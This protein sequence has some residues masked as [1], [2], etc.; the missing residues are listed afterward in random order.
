MIV[1][2][3]HYRSDDPPADVAW[4]LVAV[5]L[6]DLA[7]KGAKPVGALLGY[8]LGDSDWD[9]AFAQGLGTA[10]GA[11]G[12]P[13]LGGDTVAMPQGAPRALG[14]TALG[15]TE[16]APARSGAAPGDLL[17]VSGTIGDA[18]AGLDLLNR[19]RTEPAALIE[20]YRNPRPRLEAGQRLTPL[21]TAM[22]DVSDGLLI[23]ASRMAHASGCGAEIELD[24]I[25]L[26]DALLAER[27]ADRSARLDAATA[28]DDYEL[29]FAAAPDGAPAILALA[30]EIGLPFTRIGRFESGAGLILRDA[31]GPVPLPARTGFE[32]GR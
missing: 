17:W 3:V 5:N 27:G 14:L 2:G 1:E 8:A 22:M 32:H 23:D 20:R 19:D 11:F 24:S 15:T 7:G 26:S 4:K 30:D 31:T 6:S 9:A 13:L 18:G 28:G 25:P 29:L 10:L 16:V 21:V 12:V